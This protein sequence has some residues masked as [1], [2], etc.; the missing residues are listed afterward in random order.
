MDAVNQWVSVLAL[1]Q[2]PLARAALELMGFEIQFVR[3]KEVPGHVK[4]VG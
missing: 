3:T 1:S 4:V 2:S